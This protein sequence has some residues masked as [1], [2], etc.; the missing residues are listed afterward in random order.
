MNYTHLSQPER[1]Q[2]YALLKAGFSLPAIASTL[3]RHRST[4]H[5]EISR[6]SGL[7][8][9]RPRQAEMLASQRSERSRNAPKIET[10]L[11]R[12]VTVLLNE[13]LSPEQISAQLEVSHETIYK[14]VYVINLWEEIYIDI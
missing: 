11:W 9:Y 13:K 3:G 12:S 7:R 4:I 8:G 6:N 14:H 10:S 2:I 1:Y 5:R